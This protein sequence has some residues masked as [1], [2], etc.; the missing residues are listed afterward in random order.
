MELNKQIEF[1]TTLGDDIAF[2]MSNCGTDEKLVMLKNSL[3]LD[4]EVTDN[5]NDIIFAMFGNSN[6]EPIRIDYIT[7]ACWDFLFNETKKGDILNDTQA[8][9]LMQL[10]K[11]YSIDGNVDN[12]I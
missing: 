11:D 8:T 7:W 2:F 6:D 12:S 4:I 1:K 10:L 3:W 9:K 5:P